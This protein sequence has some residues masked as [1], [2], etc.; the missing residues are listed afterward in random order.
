MRDGQ[1]VDAD[2]GWC[3]E[4]AFALEAPV[5][6]RYGTFVGQPRICAEVVWTPADR[7]VVIS[8]KRGDERFEEFVS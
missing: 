3:D 4:L 2:Y 6:D 7:L 8:R 1:V 5:W